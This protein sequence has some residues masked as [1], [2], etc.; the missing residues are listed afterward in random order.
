MLLSLCSFRG[1]LVPNSSDSV[2]PSMFREE[3]K[4]SVHEVNGL[5]LR[6]QTEIYIKLVLESGQRPNHYLSCPSTQTGI[7]LGFKR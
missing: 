6:W 4:H 7:N 5:D 3:F 2:N 1:F